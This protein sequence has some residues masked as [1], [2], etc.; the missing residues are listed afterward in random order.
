MSSILQLYNQQ[1]RNNRM[2]DKINL[3][4]KLTLFS[5]HW[6]PKIVGEL[7]EQ[8]VKLAKVKG[9]MVWHDHENEDELFY[10]IKG[11][12]LLKFRD[13]EVTLKEGDMYIVP[14]GVEHQPIAE[15]ECHLLLFEPK[16]TAH[17]GD[18]ESEL[19]VKN[20]DWI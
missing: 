18:V 15:E 4:E 6:T 10:I 9:E 11:Q 7:N 12:L 8:Y 3:K 14:R 5:E 13:K 17:T 16:S 19:T 2:G 1:Q 20:L